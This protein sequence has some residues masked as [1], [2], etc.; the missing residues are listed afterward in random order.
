MSASSDIVFSGLDDELRLLVAG[1]VR[2]LR[3]IAP[4]IK[5]PQLT[6]VL[7]SAPSQV[8]V[9][10][11]TR[12]RPEEV[13]RGVSDLGVFDV[14]ERYG[15]D[16]R[17][18]DR[19]HAKIFIADGARMLVGSAN[20][21]ARG[22]GTAATPNFEVLMP[23]E[24]TRRSAVMMLAAIDA[25]SR[26]ATIHERAA[27]AKAAEAFAKSMPPFPEIAPLIEERVWLP[28]F[29]SPDRLYALYLD[30]SRDETAGTN[31]VAVGDMAV[32]GLPFGLAE[33]EFDS[34]VRTRL[35]MKAPLGSLD[36]FL[37]RPRRFGE[38][39]AWIASVRPDTL[40]V[41]RQRIAQTFVRWLVHFFSDRYQIDTPNHSEILSLRFHAE[42]TTAR[43]D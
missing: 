7:A 11:T 2:D 17:L 16:L 40:H 23:C 5:V 4:F 33:L 37:S 8:K 18:F 43:A 3:L 39:S 38:L 42:G 1:A 34:V 13:A 32:L 10:V 21:T 35:R 9:S 36:T 30:L 22:L 24:P 14:C 12:W 25:E 28:A 20:L 31:A 6:D 29:R 19:L 27:V 26:L 15:A 41:E